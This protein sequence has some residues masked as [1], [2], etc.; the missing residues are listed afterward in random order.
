MA[1]LVIQMGNWQLSLVPPSEPLPTDVRE[2]VSEAYEKATRLEKDNYKAWHSWAMVSE[3]GGR[4]EEI[5][6]RK[7]V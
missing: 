2:R 6:N 3:R 1:T 4:R 7:I 5:E